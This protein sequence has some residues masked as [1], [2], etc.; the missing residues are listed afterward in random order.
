MFRSVALK[1][2]SESSV[3]A[4]FAA[5]RNFSTWDFLRAMTVAKKDSI[6]VSKLDAA[7]KQLK[8]AI[9]LWFS[10]ED[11]VSAHS[12]AYAAYTLIDEFTKAKIPDREGLLF[13]SK[14]F[15]H[16]DRKLFIKVYR[17][18]GNFFKHADRDP[19]DTLDFSPELTRIFFN[20][21]LCGLSQANEPFVCDEVLV[22]Q[23]WSFFNNPNLI[24]KDDCGVF[25]DAFLAKYSDYVCSLTKREFFEFFT[26][27][28][29]TVRVKRP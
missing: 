29:D 4:S 13:D 19:D 24:P 5:S 23:A 22:F 28:L 2:S 9:R 8:T 18:S 10:E 1:C 20:F 3:P 16:D 11:P 26:Q 27:V 17:H 15:T 14:H 6:R 21:A 7:V 12:L 25:T